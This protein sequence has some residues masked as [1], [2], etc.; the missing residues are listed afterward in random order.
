MELLR[1][2]AIIDRVV[3]EKESPRDFI[4]RV[5]KSY[6]VLAW[7]QDDLDELEPWQ[8]QAAKEAQ[9]SLDMQI[10]YVRSDPAKLTISSPG[11]Q[12]EWNIYENEDGAETAAI[13]Q[14]E[15]DLRDS[16]ENFNQDWLQGH[17]D[18]DKLDN[19]LWS[20]Y[21]EHYL[22]QSYDSEDEWAEFLVDKGYLDEDDLHTEDE[23]GDQVQVDNFSELVD[24]AKDSWIDAQ[25]K[26]F[27]GMAYLE[28]IYGAED[29]AKQAIEMVGIDIN[30]AAKEAVATDG[31]A[32]FLSHYDSN[33]DTLHSGAVIMRIN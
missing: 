24:A 10:R 5:S 20:D 19:Y 25:E 32:H 11:S 9:V 3:E 18:T 28:D 27:D 29:A 13:R 16:P 8:I 12:M 21:R 17:I 4:K 1:A 23:D 2:R 7:D 22:E 26:D 6:T 33:Y 14:V 31:F 15:D 30:A